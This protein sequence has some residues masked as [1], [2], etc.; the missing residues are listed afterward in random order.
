MVCVNFIIIDISLLNYTFTINNY[1]YLY[2][3]QGHLVAVE[4]D[5]PPLAAVELGET[6]PINRRIS[7][8]IM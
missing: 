2:I 5:Q 1:T 8:G 6:H 4:E 7:S 3:L